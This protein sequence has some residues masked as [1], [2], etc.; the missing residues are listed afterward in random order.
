LDNLDLEKEPIEQF[1][2]F[3][4]VAVGLVSGG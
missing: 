1:R 4:I 3:I 2:I